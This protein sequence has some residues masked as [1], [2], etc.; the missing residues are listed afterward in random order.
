MTTPAGRSLAEA[1]PDLPRPGSAEPA[2]G[3]ITSL[4]FIRGIAVLG[5]LAANIVAF[6]Q[7]MTAYMYPGAFLTPHGPAEDWMWV[8]QFVLIDGKMRGLFTLLFG[9]GM[10]L[11]MDRAWAKG[12]GRALQARRLFWLAVFGLL[13]FLL[14]WHGDILFTYAVTGFLVLALVRLPAKRQLALGLAGY[15]TGCLLYGAMTI[16]MAYVARA[17]LAPGSSLIEMQKGLAEARELDLAE[18]RAEGELIMDGDYGAW[19]AHTLAENAL[20]PLVFVGIFL[21]ETAPL[22]LIGMALYRLGLFDG[23]IAAARL[24]RWGWAGIIFG[25]A[26]TV[27]IAL[28]TLRGGL[29]Y[30]DT[31][32]AFMGWSMLPRLAVILGLVALLAEWAPRARG[33]LGRRFAAAGRV[34]FSNYLGTS[35]LMMLVFHGWAGGLF[36]ELTRG[37]LY[38]V[39]LGAWAVMLAWPAWWLA[40]FRY[41]PLEWLWRCLTYGERLPLRR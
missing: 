2:G 34:A 13:H 32:A 19:V 24:R 3:R 1:T 39:M 28:A 36:G 18:G 31:L 33:W 15:V 6:G 14:L 30:Y 40:H 21:F 35:L 27:P 22:M 4:D 12:A 11:F 37:E 17:E 5:I 29:T 25:T 7:P 8:A 41:G 16:P 10:Y 20:D 26:L 38:L 9:A 23:R